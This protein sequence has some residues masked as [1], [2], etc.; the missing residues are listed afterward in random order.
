M[1]QAGDAFAG[2][3]FHC[4]A[5][6]YTQ[7]ADFVNAFPDKEVYFT[8]CTGTYGSDW[9]QDIKVHMHCLTLAATR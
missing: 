7:M 2:V 1:S 8:E 5:G 4:Y 6:Q 9:W 3:Q